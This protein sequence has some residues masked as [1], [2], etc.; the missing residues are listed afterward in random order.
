[1][2]YKINIA[3]RYGRNWNNTEDA[4]TFHF[5]IETELFGDSLKELVN[6]VR[7]HYPAPDYNVTVHKQHAYSEEVNL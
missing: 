7:G 1:M 2:T 4:Y 5:R 6:E 3:K